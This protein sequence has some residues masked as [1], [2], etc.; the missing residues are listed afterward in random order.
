MSSSQIVS[1]PQ[2]LSGYALDETG[3]FNGSTDIML[4]P[5][6][7]EQV[8]GIMKYCNDHGI[9]V[10]PRGAGTSLAGNASSVSGGI[11]LALSMMNKIISLDP[12]NK[13]V[14]VEAGCIAENLQNYALDQNLYYPVD[15]A[16]SGTSLIGGHVMTNA[17]GPRAYKY[18]ST[19]QYVAGLKAVLADGNVIR[20]GTITDK[21]STGYNL[22][23][24][25]T[26]SEGTLAIVTEIT[27]KL[28]N[29]PGYNCTVLMSFQ[30]LEHGLEAILKL[31]SSSIDI[32]ALEFMER[33]AL[34]IVADYE[35][36]QTIAIEDNCAAHL[37]IEVEAFSQL[38]L[39]EYLI[40]LGELMEQ[41]SHLNIIVADTFE[42][43]ERLWRV[44]KLIGHAV[45]HYSAY[46]EVDTVVPVDRLTQLIHVVR[47]TG[48]K[49]GFRSI[50]YGHAG[51][52]N[53]HVNILKEQ[54]TE[55]EWLKIMKDAVR[56]IFSQVISMGG[57]LSGEHGIGMLNKSFMDLQFSKVELELMKN[58]K[59]A[60]DPN[61]ILNPGKI[62]PE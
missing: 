50:C 44:R 43:K 46:R 31:K 48:Q 25:L 35:G 9:S 18:G 3:N 13:Y 62:F 10:T 4:F 54:F 30:T 20:T 21:N 37:L 1:D 51:N 40:Q 52:G 59:K 58:I 14:V 19:K 12:V 8:S 49:Y 53:L 29:K 23:Q 61:G 34:D 56:E 15:P 11:L 39:D 26:G 45:R 33:D 2:I 41:L 27:L 17:S 24:L 5:D 38:R 7:T 36:I 28:V 55:E 60:F 42:M 47:K 6:N 22:T 32:S 57:A 16:S